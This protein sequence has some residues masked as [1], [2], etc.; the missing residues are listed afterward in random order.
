MQF[1]ITFLEGVMSFISPCMLPMLPVY[2]G[3]F[4][5]GT[6]EKKKVFVHALFFVLGFTVIFSLLGVFAGSIGVLLQ[7]YRRIVDLVSGG[8]VILFGL[9]YLELIHLPFFKGVSSG[10]TVS[11]IVSAFLF[12][13][14]YSVSLT[15]CVGPFLGSAVM[16]ASHAETVWTGLLLLLVYSM[17]LGLPFIL[18]AILIERLRGTFAWVKRHYRVINLICGIFLILVGLV[19]AFGW[20][21]TLMRMVL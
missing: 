2:V 11:G 20:L 17:G 16:M 19:M 7:R 15:P 8:I 9:S 18:S 5:G 12:G 1:L 4:A 21:D 10:K 6:G 3:Y 13:V 14:V